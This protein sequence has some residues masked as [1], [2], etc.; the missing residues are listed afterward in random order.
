ML[1]RVEVRKQGQFVTDYIIEATSAL[2]AMNL[3][4]TYY[5]EPVRSELVQVEDTHARKRQI[6]TVDNWH[7]YTFDA[8]ALPSAET[9]AKPSSEISNPGEQIG[10]ALITKQ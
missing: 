10:I 7:G 5:G 3:V 9:Q 2:A 8:R 1:Y 4:E 6:L